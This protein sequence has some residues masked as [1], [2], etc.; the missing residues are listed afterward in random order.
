M[1]PRTDAE[2]RTL[3]VSRRFEASPQRL[4]DAW[5]DPDAVGAWL[6][7]TPGGISKHVE[8]DARVGGGFAIHE[9]RGETLATHFG[10]YLEIVRPS[11]L[12][13]TFAGDR[14]GPSSVVAIDIHADG[15]GSLLTLTHRLD[16]DWADFEASIRAGWAG[17]LEGLARSLRE[18]DKGHTLVLRRTFE[19]PRLL[20]WKAWTEAE[21]L[22][23]WLCPA[24]FEVLFAD[25]DAR[26]GGR[27]RSGMRSPQGEDYI[28]RGEYL[29]VEPPSHL[30]F[31]HEW[32]RND[33][34]PRVTTEVTIVLIES[35]GKTQM[36]F[37]QSG[38]GSA[39]SAL[40]HREGWSGAFDALERHT[41][42]S[43][44]DRPHSCT[45]PGG[46]MSDPEF[47][48]SRAFD[49]PRILLW[50]ALTE[51]ERMARWWGPK[52]FPVIAAKM[53]FRPGGTYHYGLK[54]PDGG[55]MWGRFVY[56]EIEEPSR[57]VLVN[58]F[59][60]ESGGIT[61]HPMS[62]SWPLQLL[63]TFTLT[64]KG[65]GAELTVRWRPLD[66]T[67]EES[68]TFA[69]ATQSM[70]QGWTGTLDQLSDYLARA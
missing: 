14:N 62:E 56:R 63:S 8:I 49:A 66:A 15:S 70:T 57:I 42:A 52:G 21:H 54:T 22:V 9:Q 45:N 47:V 5:L 60:D 37:I 35:D 1:P 55:V 67:A 19:A 18:P 39:E 43:V 16:P 34:E 36:T 64:E 7:A 48:I 61:R 69:A 4:F 27:W 33:L 30:V 65:A 46:G 28:H 58:S 53:D 12:V 10:T 31:T 24:G 13:F 40:S 32:E 59:S 44:N 2:G 3:V 50:K 20:V 68:E 23:R 6:F 38:L 41:A 25:A 29:V 17:I 51:P 11:R 26:V